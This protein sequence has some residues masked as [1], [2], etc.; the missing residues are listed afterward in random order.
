VHL[1]IKT[2]SKIYSSVELCDRF[3]LDNE[4]NVIMQ[5]QTIFCKS[6]A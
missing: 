3:K 4:N 6:K 1:L 2:T 5:I